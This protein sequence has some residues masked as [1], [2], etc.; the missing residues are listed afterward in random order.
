MAEIFEALMV[1][2]FG[3]SW[4]VS[5]MKSYRAKTA[6][7][8]SVVFLFFIFAGY[9]CGILSKL[10]SNRM[11]YVFIFYVINLFMVGIDLILYFRNRKRDKKQGDEGCACEDQV[12]P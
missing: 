10:L 7:G 5:I 6:K 11:T 1:I 2:G 8:K 12:T 4:P 3:I 9:I